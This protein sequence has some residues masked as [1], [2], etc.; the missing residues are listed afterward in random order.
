MRY[1]ILRRN[2]K[3]AMIDAHT[4]FYPEYVSENPSKWAAERGETYWAALVGPRPDGKRSLQ[5]FPDEKKFLDDM[6][7]A[8]V[9][10]AVIQGWYW[11][12]PDTC[13]EINRAVSSFAAGHSDRI[14]AFAAVQPAF[15]DRAAQTAKRAREAG[16]CGIGEIHDGVQKFKYGA[17]GFEKLAEACL[18]EGLPLCVHLTERG[19]RNYHGKVATDSLAAFEAAK[20][21]RGLN[22]IFAHWLGNALFDDAAAAA[23]LCSQNNVFFDSAASPL[24]SPHNAW[25]AAVSAFPDSAV[26]GSD[27]PLRLYPKKFIAEEMK[28]IADESRENVPRKHKKAFFEE[29]IK[30]ALKRRNEKS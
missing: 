9:E 28:T 19:G 27:Y 3:P 29:N 13:D 10:R 4:H 2:I 26:Y 15:G 17:G 6:D 7:A 21:F 14:S 16:F 20:K 5:G 24:I 1:D 11:E 22:F 12:N 30:I 18:S 23:E 25:E 8:G